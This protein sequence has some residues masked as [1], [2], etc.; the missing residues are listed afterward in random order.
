MDHAITFQSLWMPPAEREPVCTPQPIVAPLEAPPAEHGD[1]SD[2]ALQLVTIVARAA[3]EALTGYRPFAQL[4]RWLSQAAFDGLTMAKRHGTWEGTAITR[5]WA[6]PIDANTIE[7]VAHL[8]IGGRR[9]AVPMRLE[10]H[11]GQWGC[12][13]LSVLLPGTHQIT[14]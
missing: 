7:G 11:S 13:Q 6:S 10:R 3:V 8:S 5:I 1:A 2:Q 12:A 9:V 4:R 14:E